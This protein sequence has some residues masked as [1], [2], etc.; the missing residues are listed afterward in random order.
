MLRTG[1]GTHASEGRCRQACV[2][3]CPACV[4]QCA[5][6]PLRDGSASGHCVHQRL[7]RGYGSASHQALS[8]AMRSAAPCVAGGERR[9]RQDREALEHRAF[10][11]L[12]I[13]AQQHQQADRI[14]LP[15]LGDQA[16]DFLAM[17]IDRAVAR[18]DG[19]QRGDEGRAGRER[20]RRAGRAIAI[21]AHA[22]AL[23]HQHLAAQVVDLHPAA[24]H[25]QAAIA[26]GVDLEQ[27]FAAE[28]DHLRAGHAHAELPRRRPHPRPQ[29]ALLQLH[30]MAAGARLDQA[31]ARARADRDF[32]DAG[33]AQAGHRVRA[34]FQR[35]VERQARAP[36][37]CG[38]R[39]AHRPAAPA[40]ATAAP[41]SQCRRCWNQARTPSAHTANIAAAA[42]ATR[43]RDDARACLTGF[44]STRHA[45]D[46]AHRHA[47]ARAAGAPAAPSPDPP[48]RCDPT[49]SRCPCRHQACCRRA[50]ARRRSSHAR[51]RCARPSVPRAAAPCRDAGSPARCRRSGRCA[52]R[53]PGR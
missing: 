31:H 35:A 20:M 46:V 48:D 8:T 41:A 53:S 30:A 12:R 25:A 16:A 4:S 18:I 26:V 39:C 36:A 5:I 21:H 45:L 9:R 22:R 19:F 50:C 49:G 11:E 6:L 32:T 43:Q 34:G 7:T 17:R 10:G 37:G 27:E 38:R 28:V 15:R 40:P 51:S 29:A 47:H 13:I 14:L 24:E 52:R 3:R 1:V 44:G 2:N 42:R 23:R 33:R